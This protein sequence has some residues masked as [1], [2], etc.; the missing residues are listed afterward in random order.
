MRLALFLLFPLLLCGQ[1]ATG[2]AT[3]SGTCGLANT[4]AIGSVVINC[5][6]GRVQ[7]QKMIEIL[8]KI[9]ANQLDTDTV[10]KLLED[11]RSG[12]IRIENGVLKLASTV[13]RI[14]E[15]QNPRTLTPQ[16]SRDFGVLLEQ[17][18]GQV[19]TISSYDTEGKG[20]AEFL[21]PFFERSGWIAPPPASKLGV[22]QVLGFDGPTPVGVQVTVNKVDASANRFPQSAVALVN[23]F[24]SLGMQDGDRKTMFVND[25]VPSGQIELRVGIKPPVR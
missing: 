15:Q 13:D 23:F 2:N 9:L 6:I 8:N 10:S 17:F 21:I 20:F 4:A 7:G 22:I 3:A 11:L 25:S 24:F 14:R 16:Q 1:Q 19:F 5:G 12:Q 18:R